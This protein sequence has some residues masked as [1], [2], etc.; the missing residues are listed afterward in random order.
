MNSQMIINYIFM[1]IL[2]ITFIS[3]AISVRKFL[4]QIAD[5]KASDTLN[6]IKYNEE[7]IIGHLDYII[8]EALNTYE[9]LNIIPKDIPYINSNMEQEILDYLVDEVPGRI[10]NTLYSTLSYIYSNEYIG[11]FI[12]THIYMIVLNYVLNYNQTRV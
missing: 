10:S 12:G 4:R 7:E 1:A 5:I 9:V 2:L 8:D 3:I 6:S 11:E